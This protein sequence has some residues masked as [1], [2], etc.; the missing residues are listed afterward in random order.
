MATEQKNGK[1]KNTRTRYLNILLFY[2]ICSWFW[3]RFSFFLRAH[4]VY[5][6]GYS[7]YIKSKRYSGSFCI[8]C[9]KQG[10]YL[11]LEALLCE[12]FSVN[13]KKLSS[14]SSNPSNGF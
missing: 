9:E 12:I 2:C 1:R 14:F 10:R 6:T 7:W 3:C 4:K 11:Q 5:F 8:C 13:L